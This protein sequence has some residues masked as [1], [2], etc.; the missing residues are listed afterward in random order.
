[1]SQNKL[2][3][4]LSSLEDAK[5]GMKNPS[6][7]SASADLQA[8]GWA[9]LALELRAPF[10]FAASV[11][12][13]PMLISAP[14]GDGH[15]VIVYPGF[16]G[17]DRSTAPMR[18]LLKSLGHDVQGWGLGRNTGPKQEVM[19]QALQRI[20]ELA[21]KSGRSVSLVG[22]SLGGVYAREL[23]KLAPA[24]VRQ[25]VT[26][27]SPFVVPPGGPAGEAGAAT[28]AKR[29]YQFVSRRQQHI[30]PDRDAMK[31]APP[32]PTTSIYSRSDG[33]V[34][35]QCSVQEKNDGAQTESIEVTASHAGLGVNP[36]A[37]YALA[38]RL[39]QAPGQWR[40]FERSGFRKL[41]FP[42]MTASS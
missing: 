7:D 16:M 26:L 29:L 20:Q 40:P 24:D 11:A 8:P 4:F 10:E 17:T 12:A 34:A 19:D 42:A 18:R 41:C 33:I 39:A 21:Q 30:K 35:W 28:N 32:V 27:G 2:A 1:V 6:Q 36:T 13:A 15:S 22:W 25:V 9:R 37:L 23:A 14:R 5:L 3:V 31:Q 38:D